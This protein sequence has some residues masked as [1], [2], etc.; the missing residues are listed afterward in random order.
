MP[1]LVNLTLEQLRAATKAQIVADITAKMTKR[2]LLIFLNDGS[3]KVQDEPKRTYCKDGQQ[4]SQIEVERDVETGARTGGKVISWSYYP[5]GEVDEITISLRD[6]TDKETA[7][8][9]IK[10]FVDGR[11]PETAINPPP[12]PP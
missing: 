12:A 11:Q 2:D 4:E 1:I 8:K 3:D 7:R 5:T 6:A 9:V 10:H